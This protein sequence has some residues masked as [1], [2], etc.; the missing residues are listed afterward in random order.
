M[1]R[2]LIHPRDEAFSI[3][4]VIYQPNY[5]T[6]DFILDLKTFLD[7]FEFC[8]VEY[9]KY[10]QI[11]K[12]PRLT[13]CYGQYNKEPT[14]RYRGV[15]FSTEPIPQ[16]LLQ[17]KAPIEQF[18]GCDFNAVIMNKYPT[19][20][21]HIGWHQ[22]DES[23]LEHNTIASLTIGAERPFQ[24]RHLDKG[25]I[26]EVELKSGSLLIFNQGLLHS[27]PKRTRVSGVRYNITFRKVKSGLGI[28]NYYYYN[29]KQ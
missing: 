18:L 6:P 7:Q 2:K 13:Y 26:H 1:A 27:L 15:D 17:L 23:F 14:A 21:H 22:D 20:D 8:Q 29:R 28:G 11:R 9:I 16:W 5:C 25:Q 24:F 3:P 4:Q 10:G 12:T 19:G